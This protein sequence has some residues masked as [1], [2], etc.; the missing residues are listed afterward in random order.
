[1][2]N[3]VMREK[4]HTDVTFRCDEH[5]FRISCYYSDDLKRID[6]IS[7]TSRLVKMIVSFFILPFLATA[8]AFTGSSASHA[9]IVLQSHGRDRIT[10]F[11]SSTDENQN[12]ELEVEPPNTVIGKPFDPLPPLTAALIIFSSNAAFADSP[13]WGLFEGRTGSILHPITMFG[14][15]ALSVSTALLGFEWRRQVGLL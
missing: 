4:D 11:S 6:I 8:D 3:T 5:I 9:S 12:F 14:M 10:R 2:Q 15:L 13:D 7:T 1:M